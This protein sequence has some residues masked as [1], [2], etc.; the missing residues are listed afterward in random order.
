MSYYAFEEMKRAAGETPEDDMYACRQYTRANEGYERKPYKDIKGHWTCGVGHKMLHPP[1]EDELK[2][3]WS[4]DYIESIFEKDFIKACKSLSAAYPSWQK[5]SRGRRKA[6]L[7]MS[8]NM[9]S[10]KGF[11]R[12]LKAVEGKDYDLAAWEIE[13]SL[14]FSQLGGDPSGTDDGKDERPEKNARLMRMG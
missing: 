1:T 13:S 5:L 6:L 4:D 10:V 8:F 11:K 2:H 9:G 14:Y 3:G 12:M 7:D